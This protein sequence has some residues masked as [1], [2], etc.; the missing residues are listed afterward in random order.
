MP[1]AMNAG[2]LTGEGALKLLTATH[3]LK[4]MKTLLFKYLLNQD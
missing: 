1:H 4:P 2:S 3:S